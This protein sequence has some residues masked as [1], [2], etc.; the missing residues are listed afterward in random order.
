MGLVCDPGCAQWAKLFDDCVC[1][2]KASL[3]Q[4]GRQSTFA[5]V[6]VGREGDLILLSAGP[7]V[8][9]IRYPFRPLLRQ[10]LPATDHFKLCEWQL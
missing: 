4:V 1:T 2:N 7:R 8:V 5:C 10:L 9:P 3:P 6:V